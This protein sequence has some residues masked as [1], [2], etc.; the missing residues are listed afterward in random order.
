MPRKPSAGGFIDAYCTKCK[1]DLGHTV[2]CLVGEKI[3][4]VKCRTCGS[5]H[6][7]RDRAKKT[8]ARKRTTMSAKKALLM[9][10]PEGVWVEAMNKATGAEIPYD[11]I[12][13][14]KPGQVVAHPVFG[15]G[16]VLEAA[17]KKVTIIFKDKERKLVSGN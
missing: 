3:A 15:S 1:V 17:E 5:E 7:Y 13:L 6:N 10:N 9:K 14:Y 8:A 16:V 11:G 2:I 4:R 12:R